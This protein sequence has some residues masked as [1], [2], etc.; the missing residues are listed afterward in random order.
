[1]VGNKEEVQVQVPLVKTGTISG[2]IRFEY[3][4]LLSFAVDRDLAGQSI[5]ATNTEGKSYETKTDDKGQYMLYLPTG[6]Y[7]VTVAKL[8][9]QIEVLTDGQNQQPV[10]VRSGKVLTG[11]DFILKVK[12]RKIDVKK[13]GQ[14]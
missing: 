11:F 4:E 5:I 3:D 13:F 7:T 1:M 6:N 10:E 12:Q 2:R 9:N 14:K 8:P